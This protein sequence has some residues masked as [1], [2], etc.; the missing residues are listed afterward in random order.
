MGRGEGGDENRQRGEREKHL[1][2]KRK[3]TGRQGHRTKREN[4]AADELEET[5][6]DKRAKREERKNTNTIE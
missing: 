3:P 5:K 6:K 2:G 1:R 4:S